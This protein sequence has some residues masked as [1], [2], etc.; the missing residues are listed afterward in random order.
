MPDKKP[1]AAASK[2]TP[3]HIDGGKI[4]PMTV[5][6]KTAPALL[7]NGDAPDV[8]SK[9]TMTLENGVTYR[10]TVAD[11]VEAGGEVMVEFKDGLS[12]VQK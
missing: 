10:A 12:P 5:G 11:V 8:G 4:V 1:A 9:I 3:I 6:D 2:S 7:F